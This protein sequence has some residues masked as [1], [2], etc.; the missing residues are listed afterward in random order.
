MFHEG[1]G[2]AE[3]KALYH[4]LQGSLSSLKVVPVAAV[5]IHAL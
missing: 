1:G 4:Q 2:T 5:F 3:K